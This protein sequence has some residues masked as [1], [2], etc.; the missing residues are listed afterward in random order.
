MGDKAF[1]ISP[2]NRRSISYLELWKDVSDTDLA[3]SSCDF[4]P[5]DFY[6]SMRVL[7]SCLVKGSRVS[8]VANDL[9]LP[10]DFD[11][12]FTRGANADFAMK[13]WPDPGCLP[14][15]QRVKHGIA[16]V[17]LLSSGTSGLSNKIVHSAGSILNSVRVADKRKNDVWGIAYHPA[18]YAGI[19]LFCQAFFNRNSVVR[20][21]GYRSKLIHQ[22]IEEHEVS[23]LGGTPTQMKLLCGKSMARRHQNVRH[24]AIG[25]ERIG[26]TTIRD[27]HHVFPNAKVTNHYALTESH[28]AFVSKNDVFRVNDEQENLVRIIDGQLALHRQLMAESIA[29]HIESEFYLTGDQVEIVDENPLRFKVLGRSSTVVNVGGYN[30]V[31]EEI[32]Q[33]LLKMEC[34]DEARVY[35]IKNSVTGNVLGCDLVLVPNISSLTAL[36]IRQ[37]LSGRLHGYKIPRIFKFVSQLE[38]TTS[39][40]V[41]RRR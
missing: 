21:F 24:V 40:K 34:I 12:E 38:Q 31:P 25:G 22:A 1:L 30:V 9:G 39:G 35:G 15:I 11:R 4:S 19:Q 20:L 36:D 16:T 7:A 10:E 37:F 29:S 26:P 41:S 13:S 23:H 27:I 5:R 2:M 33:L 8:L 28:A 6:E 18:H 32:E 17:E 3:N 14:D